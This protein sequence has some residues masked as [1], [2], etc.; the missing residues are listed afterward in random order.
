MPLAVQLHWTDVA[1]MAVHI[2][3]TN[4][5]DERDLCFTFVHTQ[6]EVG[7]RINIPV[8]AE[9]VIT[10]STINVT[11]PNKLCISYVS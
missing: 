11:P 2:H 7:Q 10:A 8:L 1:R 4:I 9:I 5:I 6:K 3:Y